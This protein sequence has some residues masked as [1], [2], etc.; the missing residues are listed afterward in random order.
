MPLLAVNEQTEGVAC[1][2]EHD[3]KTRA[4]A[5]RWLVRCLVASPLENQSNGC[6]DVVHEKFEVHHLRLVSELLGPDGR[7]IRFLRLDVQADAALRIAELQPAHAVA[8]GDLP[9][10]QPRIERAEYF[11][12]RAVDGERRP[13]DRRDRCHDSSVAPTDAASAQPAVGGSA[14]EM[15]VR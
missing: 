3:P 14:D 4:V 15:S 9:A 7:L 5:V 12:V 1:R 13:P 11:G 8:S 10:E 6:I 2:V